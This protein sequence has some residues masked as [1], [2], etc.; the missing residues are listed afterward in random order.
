[1]NKFSQKLGLITAL[2]VLS[3]AAIAQADVKLCQRKNIGKIFNPRTRVQALVLVD[4][5]NCPAGFRQ[6]TTLFTQEDATAAI[7][8]F[9]DANATALQG[10]QGPQGEKGEKGDK[11]DTG[12]AG[13]QGLQ[14]ET[15]PQGPKG[16]TGSQGETGAPGATGDTG[17]KGDTGDIGPKG[18][19]G[20]TGE[21][22]AKGDSGDIGPKGDKG[23]TGATGDTGP[24]GDTGDKGD[25]GATGPQG[26]PGAVDVDAC[27]KFSL[28]RTGI[29]DEE[30][31]ISCP[32]VST[33]FMLNY[34]FK[35]ESSE[36]S[37]DDMRLSKSELL[38]GDA[39]SPNKPTGVTLRTYN[40][41][42]LLGIKQYTLTVTIVCCP[43]N[44]SVPLP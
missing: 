43:I 10:D 11:G 6:I 37:L 18:D 17:A 32:D 14:G 34:G 38:F 25:T 4:G 21:T 15:G 44:S 2:C 36:A 28:S 40:E 20:D 19:K 35:T 42:D 29:R 23:D 13:A 7:K 31:T 24:K 3:Q 5:G 27:T 12:A 22:G 16:D 41:N 39:L 9:A 8:K 26:E 1:M 33:Q 30:Q